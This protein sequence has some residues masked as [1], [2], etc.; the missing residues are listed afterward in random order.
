MSDMEKA[1]QHL[2]KQLINV[3]IVKYKAEGF[4]LKSGATSPIYFDI[5][6][7]V[8]FPDKSQLL[9]NYICTYILPCIEDAIDE[10]DPV[11][12]PEDD[13]DAYIC[14]IP[15]A[16]IPI[17]T[18]ISLT[19]DIPM[20]MVRKEA[21]TYGTARQVEGRYEKGDNIIL[22][23]DVITSG[24]SLK[25]TVDILSREDLIVKHIIVCVDRRGSE[26]IGK[27]LLMEDGSKIR[28]WSI[29]TLDDLIQAFDQK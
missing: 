4:Q 8:N 10:E 22:F 17:A 11:R 5:R 14:G 29:W 9:A 18:I 21:K 27:P 1:S 6:D 16:G 12:D 28:I 25:Q 26:D 7:L 20:L 13:T 15:Y 19:A 23:D 24:S 2:L 3:G